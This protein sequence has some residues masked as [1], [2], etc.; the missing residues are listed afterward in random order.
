[1]NTTLTGGDLLGWFKFDDIYNYSNNIDSAVYAFGVFDKV[2]NK[3]S[4]PIC[5]EEVLYIGQTGGKEKT[6]DKKDK[7]TGRGRLETTF[8]SRMLQHASRDKI[9]QIRENMNNSKVLCVYLIT[10]KKWMEITQIKQWLLASES[11]MIGCYGQIFGD[12]PLHNLQHRSD[13]TTV[14]EASFSQLMV[15]E[16]KERSLDKFYD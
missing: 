10:P 3:Y 7:E 16:I 1:M 14:D 5:Q 4:L 2:P 6:F 11:E 12:A 15:K 9:K 13:N 8:H